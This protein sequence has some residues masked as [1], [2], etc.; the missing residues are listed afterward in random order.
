MER[1][2]IA[3]S[4]TNAAASR[5]RS[6]A[7][8]LRV[9]IGGIEQPIFGQRKI[10]HTIRLREGEDY[11][12][13]CARGAVRSIARFLDDNGLGIDD[14]DRIVPS[15]APVGFPQAFAAEAPRRIRKR[16]ADVG[17]P[18]AGAHTVGPAIAIEAALA[19]EDTRGARNLLFV[20]A[21]SGI[22]I[23]LALYVVPVL[24]VDS[25]SSS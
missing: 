6:V 20:A 2:R 23:A 24:G 25:G 8:A 18:I 14:I 11:V 21:G 5:A 10:E 12:D 4:A 22:T 16:C 1:S 19:S 9:N 7:S 3:Q 15:Q 17:P 13:Q